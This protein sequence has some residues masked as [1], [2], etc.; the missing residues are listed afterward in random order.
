MRSAVVF[1]G[2]GAQSVGMLNELAEK[3]PMVLDYFARASEVLGYDLW[4]VVSEGPEEKLNDTAITQPAMLVTGYACYQVLKYHLPDWQPSYFAGHS[5]GEYTALV[6]ADAL[7]LDEAVKLV[8]MRGELMQAAVPQGLGSMAAILGLTDE[9]VQQACTSAELDDIVAAV[10]YN[11]PGQVVIAG[12]V[13]A[14]ERAMANATE[15]G[16]KRVVPLSVSVP[17]HC[18]LMKPAAEKLSD[19]ISQCHWRL[20]SVAVLH[21]VNAKSSKNLA[22]L[23]AA[24]VAQLYQPVQWVK[25]IEFLVQDDITQ[26]IECGPG[27]VLAGLNRRIDRTMAVASIYDSATLANTINSIEEN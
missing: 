12:T 26:L 11:S 23:Q 8:A 9:Q 13:K 27:K 7:S 15:M 4:Q 3:F 20:P 6:A 2:Q 16:A 17:S 21:N 18:S 19:E 22:D 14:V 25:T 1:P 5:L 10:N 24:L